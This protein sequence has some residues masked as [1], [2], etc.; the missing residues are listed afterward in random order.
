M[1]PLHRMQEA[2]YRMFSSRAFLHQYQAHGLEEAALL[3]SF[4]SIEDTLAC[5]AGL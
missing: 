4:A 3:A 5:Y 2:G 1:A